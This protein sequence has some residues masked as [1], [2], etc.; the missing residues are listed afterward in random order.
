MHHGLVDDPYSKL[1]ILVDEDPGDDDALI[2]SS[3]TR[4]LHL[5]MIIFNIKSIFYPQE[6]HAFVIL[7]IRVGIGRAIYLFTCNSHCRR[8]VV[9]NDHHHW[10]RQPCKPH[11]LHRPQWPHWT[12]MALLVA[13]ASMALLASMASSTSL[14]S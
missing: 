5:S 13:S 2:D 9:M 7:Q 14:A 3:S 6:F 10:P 4:L 1:Q 8:V 12:Q 11:Q